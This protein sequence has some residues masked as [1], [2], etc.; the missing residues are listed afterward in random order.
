MS[1]RSHRSNPV[2]FG[3][4]VHRTQTKEKKRERLPSIHL[5]YAPSLQWSRVAF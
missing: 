3:Q 1:Q 2:Q 4:D 5:V